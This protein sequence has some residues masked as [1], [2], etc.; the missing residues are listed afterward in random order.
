MSSSEIVQALGPGTHLSKLDQFTSSYNTVTTNFTS[1]LQY[2][3]LQD[4]VLSESPN[5]PGQDQDLRSIVADGSSRFGQLCT[6]NISVAQQVASYGRTVSVLLK[7]LTI[8]NYASST[9]PLI[10]QYVSQAQAS[11]GDN[12]QFFEEVC[13]FSCNKN[14]QLFNLERFPVT[15][16]PPAFE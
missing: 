8:A 3:F 4:I 14:L 9:K 15:N 1:L 10:D 13:I 5:S 12:E 2:P 7:A 6:T 16:V 11:A